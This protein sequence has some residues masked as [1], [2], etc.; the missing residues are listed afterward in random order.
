MAKWLCIYIGFLKKKSEIKYNKN[1]S[2]ATT[3][4]TKP[5]KKGSNQF[6]FQFMSSF[7]I[8]FNNWSQFSIHTQIDIIPFMVFNKKNQ[9]INET[10]E[11]KK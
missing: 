7:S 9:Q 6:H 3:E 2:S 10:Q 4:A 8:S 5:Y 1:T 11:N